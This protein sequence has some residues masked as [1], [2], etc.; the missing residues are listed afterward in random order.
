MARTL[1]RGNNGR[2][3]HPRLAERSRKVTA[4]SKA[5]PK[6]ALDRGP[7]EIVERAADVG[8]ERLARTKLDILYTSVIGGIEVSIGGLAA[9]LVVGATL[10]ADPKLPLDMAL[11]LGGLA[12]PIGFIFVIMGH[13]ELFTENFLIPVVAV[14]NRKR[15]L[16]SLFELFALSWLGNM[17][18]AAIMAMLLLVPD[19][20]S[21]SIH[22]GYVTYSAYKL[23]LPLP[24]LFASAILAG[25]V[26]TALTWV[27]VAIHSPVG[28]ILAIIAGGYVLF[29][30]NLSHSIIGASLLF[31]GFVGANKQPLDVFAWIVLATAGNIVGGVGLV[32]LFRVVQAREKSRQINRP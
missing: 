13:S 24:G 2:S 10:T 3:D 8:E 14:L 23:G 5:I 11:A 20:I 30:A 4:Q 6:D 21:A 18:G 31:V 19:S 7:D 16:R 9:M 17:I 22:L 27:L 15:S 29:A 28:N 32:T 26:M 25:L 1:Q 12:F